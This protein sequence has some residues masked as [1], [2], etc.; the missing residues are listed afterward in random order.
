LAERAHALK[1]TAG[2][3]TTLGASRRD[4]GDIAGSEAALRESVALLGTVRENAPGWVALSATLRAR[5]DFAGAEEA[6]MKI[7][8][9]DEDDP[10]GWRALAYVLSDRGEALRAGDA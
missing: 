8:E 7:I 10:Y 4:V 9:N 1:V 5:G 3:L 2:S 6:A